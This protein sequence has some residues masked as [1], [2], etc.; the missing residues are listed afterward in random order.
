MLDT[1]CDNQGKFI[2]NNQQLLTNYAIFGRNLSLQLGSN[3]NKNQI[4][5]NLSI[6][7]PTNCVYGLIGSSG[8]GKTSLQRCIFGYYKPEG[9][10]LIFGKRPKGLYRILN[11]WE[12]D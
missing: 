6:T 12:D 5:H 11:A 7:V 4:F 3:W 1:C 9:T 2:D 8:C 10:L